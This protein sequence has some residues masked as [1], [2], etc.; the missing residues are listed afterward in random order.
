MRES[1]ANG[2]LQAWLRDRY[3]DRQ[4]EELEAL[5]ESG[6]G[7]DR[8]ICRI[9]GVDYVQS[10]Q[11]SDQERAAYQRKCAAI[12]QHTDDPK[13]LAHALDTATNQTELA[14]LLNAGN[15]V[16][17]LCGEH[18]NVPIRKGGVHYIGIAYPKL[19][20]SFTEE[21]Y[22]R[23]GITFEQIELPAE[24]DPALTETAQRAARE[25]GYDDFGDHHN[26]LATLF[27]QAVKTDKLT[28]W[29]YLDHNAVDVTTEFYRSK[30]AAKTAARRVVD[31]AYDKANRI[32][33]PGNKDCLADDFAQRY[34]DRL[35]KRATP[36][37]ER[38]KAGLA[39]ANQVKRLAELD[40]LINGAR[41]YLQDAFEEE[42]R[43]S[44]D[45]YKMY[46]KSYFVDRVDITAND[47]NTDLF[48][49]DLANSI[50]RV[51]FDETEYTVDGML[52][53]M[54][55]LQ[56]DMNSHGEMF[57]SS[58]YSIYKEYCQKIEAAAEELGRNLTDSDLVAM[59][60]LDSKKS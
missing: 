25:A 35:V 12:R 19:E 28:K 37:L 54:N 24:A 13:L 29:C 38:L 33:V 6:T 49:S 42:L 21:Q 34:S 26:T 47:F 59:D 18:F 39:Q 58:A 56:D 32:F 9:L 45:Y 5:R 4:A 7:T 36:I 46:K 51:F 2:I 44:A 50:A 20:A 40:K 17:Y 16:I 1:T 57:Y 27:H 10:G 3:Y 23:A 52:E 31:D 30:L 60:I 55:E 8:D 22:R 43:D 53:T 15:D 14:E 11:M 48:Q 41:A